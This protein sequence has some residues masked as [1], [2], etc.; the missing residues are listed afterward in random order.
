PAGAALARLTWAPAGSPPV[1]LVVSTDTALRTGAVSSRE[2][3]LFAP[4]G[5]AVIVTLVSAGTGE[6]LTRT[7]AVILPAGTVTLA[8]TLA[9]LG[10]LLASDTLKPPGSAGPVRETTPFTPEPPVMLGRSMLNPEKTGGSTVRSA[11]W[12]S[13]VGSAVIVT[14]V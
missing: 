6:G 7:R 14:G 5:S 8:G 9:T 11:L 1:T 4:A 2:A 12:L 10:L 3:L 13:P